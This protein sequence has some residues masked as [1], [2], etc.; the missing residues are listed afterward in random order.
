MPAGGVRIKVALFGAVVLCLVGVAAVA[1]NQE[2]AGPPPAA[3]ARPAVPTP[4][5]ALSPEEQSYM[6]ALWPIHSQVERTVLRVA[7]GAAFYKTQDL[8]R[9]ELKGRLD[10][11]LATYRQAGEQLR[12]LRPPPSLAQ[13]QA[14]YVSALDLFQQSAVEM[15]K[16]YDDGSDEHLAAGF[17]AS[18]E[19]S[20][21]IREVGSRFW[22]DE[23]PPN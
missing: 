3:G 14:T 19:G 22:P 5:P 21:R 7:L 9:E 4:R 13:T 17:P 1:I 18:L 10:E 15:L 2:V 11:A 6:Q 23:Y 8:S 16:M 20:N 12:A